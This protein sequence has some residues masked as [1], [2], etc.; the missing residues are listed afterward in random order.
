MA[1]FRQTWR[2]LGEQQRYFELP[3]HSLERVQHQQR[4]ASWRWH[5]IRLQVALDGQTRIRLSRAI[6]P[7]FSH[8]PCGDVEPRPSNGQSRYQLQIREWRFRRGRAIGRW[9]LSRAFG[10]STEGI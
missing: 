8:G 7:D 3:W 1:R 2:R 6:K 10:R 5:R 9:G 4:L